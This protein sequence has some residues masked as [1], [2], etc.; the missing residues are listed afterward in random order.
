MVGPSAGRGWRGLLPATTPRTSLTSAALCWWTF[1]TTAA[2]NA[3]L[4]V[5]LRPVVLHQ[6]APIRAPCCGSFITN[7]QFI[8]PC[9]QA[10]PEEPDGS[11]INYRRPLIL[12]RER[13]RRRTG[14]GSK[15]AASFPFLSRRVT[16]LTRS[17]R[18]RRLPECVSGKTVIFAFLRPRG[19]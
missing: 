13:Q 4:K 17:R 11:W 7:G 2:Q 5:S 16:M 12:R 10:G 1:A 19:G 8:S 18:R 14:G 15:E 6:E 3:F 9:F